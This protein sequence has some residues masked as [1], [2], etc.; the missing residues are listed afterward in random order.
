MQNV[1]GSTHT[2]LPCVHDNVGY[3]GLC[4]AD[5]APKCA[6][7]NPFYCGFCAADAALK[8]AHGNPFYCGF[9]G[10]VPRR[11]LQTRASLRAE[12]L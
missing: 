2:A 7:G 5:A 6:H 12:E 10:S 4:A 1:E 9:C 8:C 3:C 11:E